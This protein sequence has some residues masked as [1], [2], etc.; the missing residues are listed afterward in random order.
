VNKP[1]KTIVFDMDQTLLHSD[2]YPELLNDELP[3]HELVFPDGQAM[4]TNFRPHAQKAVK[5]LR[6]KVEL[7]LW[8]AGTQDY[9]ERA[10]EKFQD[11]TPVFDHSIYRDSRWWG[12]GHLYRKD[13]RRL[14]R[15]M[16]HTLIID[17]SPIVCLENR[18]N[19]IIMD[20]FEGAPDDR[21][22]EQLDGMLQRVAASPERIP[23]LLEQFAKEG[24]LKKSEDGFYRLTEH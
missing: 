18:A 11:Q 14:G 12:S 2:E 1:Q 20:A 13:L 17:D 7:V 6:N 23:K 5:K 3:V 9:A 16:D 19:A 10:M 24:L 4:Y 21:L 22:F 8:T 15:S